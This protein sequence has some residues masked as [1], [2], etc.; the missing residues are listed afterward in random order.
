MNTLQA[1][2]TKYHGPTS[3]KAGRII[4]TAYAGRIIH[5]YD[6]RLRQEGNHD[7]ACIKLAEKMGW[8]AV[9]F[10]GGMPD[11]SGNVYVQGKPG[12]GE[13]AFQTGVEE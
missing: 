8:K 11:E 6:P 4:A 9:W 10:R 5:E 7:A 12:A 13:F 2:V 3:T 1:I